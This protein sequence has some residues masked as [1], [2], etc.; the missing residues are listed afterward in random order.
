[1]VTAEAR[2]P[3]PD[4]TL[5]ASTMAT[6]GRAQAHDLLL[7]LRSHLSGIFQTSFRPE[8]DRIIEEYTSGVSRFSPR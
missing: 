6:D 1:M 7:K 4:K 5:M 8:H 3:E 2:P